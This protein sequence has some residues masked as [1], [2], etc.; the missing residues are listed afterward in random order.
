MAMSL[1]AI[2]QT[3]LSMGLLGAATSAS[4]HQVYPG[5]GVWTTNASRYTTDTI[6]LASISQVAN[7]PVL[8]FQF[9]RQA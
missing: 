1:N 2:T 5:L 8:P 7:N 3:A 6:G 9:I 4:A